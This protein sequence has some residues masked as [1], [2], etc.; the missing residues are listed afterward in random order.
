MG[1]CITDSRAVD[2]VG[3][4]L[5]VERQT[6]SNGEAISVRT[7]DSVEFLDRQPVEIYPHQ[8]LG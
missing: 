6:G 3:D 5:L 7:G 2:G 4:G 1:L 8:S